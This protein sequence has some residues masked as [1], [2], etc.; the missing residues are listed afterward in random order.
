MACQLQSA[1]FC[2]WYYSY[3]SYHRFRLLCSDTAVH[4]HF[5]Q[6]FMLHQRTTGQIHPDFWTLN[7]MSKVIC[8]W[9]RTPVI[10]VSVSLALN[11]CL[12]SP[13]GYRRCHWWRW[14]R[15][16]VCNGSRSV[17][18]EQTERMEFIRMD[19][20]VSNVTGRNYFPWLTYFQLG[21]RLV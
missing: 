19:R 1:T 2:R 11:V 17:F 13:S 14:Q 3:C 8:M 20:L 18:P 4:H 10:H 21:S 9:S 5:S 12:D 6:K 15:I 16:P 7:Y